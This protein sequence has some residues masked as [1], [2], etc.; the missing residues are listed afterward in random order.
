MLVTITSLFLRAAAITGT[1]GGRNKKRLWLS[2]N[3][4]INP[5]NLGQQQVENQGTEICPDNI[6]KKTQVSDTNIVLRSAIDAKAN[7]KQ[8]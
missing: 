4:G 5:E 3:H 6:S 1:N 2:D 8:E 7:E